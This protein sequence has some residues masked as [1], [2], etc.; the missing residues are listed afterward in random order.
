[1]RSASCDR[2]F[3]GLLLSSQAHAPAWSSLPE[4]ILWGSESGSGSEVKSC[5]ATVGA[6]SEDGNN[7]TDAGFM[8]ELY[9][10][11]YTITS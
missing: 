1:M 2:H 6:H 10:K 7:N 9:S 3:A 4:S 8:S 11:E 5:S